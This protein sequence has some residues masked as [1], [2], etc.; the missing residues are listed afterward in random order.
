MR[1]RRTITNNHII[2]AGLFFLLLMVGCKSSQKVATVERGETKAHADFFDSMQEQAF[3]FHTLSARMQIELTM[4]G[5]EMSSRVDLKMVKDSAFHL[6][7]QPLLNIELFRIEL[8][9]DSIRIIDRMN[10]RYVAESYANLKGQIPVTFNF[11][12]LQSLFINHIFLPGEQQ[13]DPSRYNRFRLNQEG[14]MAEANVKDPMG[15]LYT[16]K[17][18]GEEKLLSTH[19]TNASETYAVQWDY[20]NFRI[21]EGQ[22]FPMLMHVGLWGDGISKGDIKMHF[23]R[24]QTNIPV[25]VGISIPGSSYKRITFAEILKAFSSSR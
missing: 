9:R 18:D 4:Q 6:S 2:M 25:Q 24:I 20:S 7:I 14:R 19:I 17:V 21:N 11:Y 1:D 23:N 15:L 12:N 16:F 10:K 8:N 13:I 22:P 5:K 3:R